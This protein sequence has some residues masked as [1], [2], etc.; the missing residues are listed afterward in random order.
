MRVTGADLG[1][2]GPCNSAHRLRQRCH[3]LV[4]T[5]LLMCLGLAP[6]QGRTAAAGVRPLARAVDTVT[7]AQLGSGAAAIRLVAGADDLYVIVA[8]GRVQ[9]YILHGLPHADLFTQ[10]MRWKEGANGLIMGRPLDLSLVGD[11]LLILDDRASL[12]SYQGAAYARALV[13]L[14]V[15]SS[16]GRLDAVATHAGDLLAL[17]RDRRRIW[18]YRAQGD[19]YDTAPRSLAA[20]P[21]GALAGATRLAASSNG[22]LVLTHGT[23]LL[24]P[25]NRPDAGREL[26]LD[27]GISGVWAAESHHRFL[28]SFARAV[29]VCAPSGHVDEVL[30][31]RGLHGETVRDVA[32]DPTG[33]LY[34]LTATR[35]LRVSVT[36]PPL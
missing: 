24:W 35:I 36:I 6:S 25:W 19:G 32:L 17:D 29:A 15:Q 26:R 28:V 30:A 18:W 7:V 3:P 10:V 9:R 31:L 14:R 5:A 1:S 16:Q 22:L 34:V 2:R 12:W 27:A 21:I 4:A 23:V 20:R 11:R 13:A 8:P 33:R